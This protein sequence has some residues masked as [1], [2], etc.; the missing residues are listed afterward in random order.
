MYLGKWVTP[1]VFL[2]NPKIL[3]CQLL[4][5]CIVSLST[6]K[7]AQLSADPNYSKQFFQKMSLCNITSHIS[8]I[9]LFSVYSQEQWPLF[10]HTWLRQSPG[11]EAAVWMRQLANYLICHEMLTSPKTK[12]HCSRRYRLPQSWFLPQPTRCVS[13]PKCERKV[14]IIEVLYAHASLHFLCSIFWQ[15]SRYPKIK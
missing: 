5:W 14:L 1:F 15:S 8:F 11:K 4:V 3:L 6:L 10:L 7:D 9:L 12:Q 13:F 2:L